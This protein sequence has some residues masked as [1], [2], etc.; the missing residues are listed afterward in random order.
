MRATAKRP[1]KFPKATN[2]NS[3]EKKTNYISDKPANHKIA[4]EI[5][6]LCLHP[7]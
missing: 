1:R 4:K 6:I 5:K 2:T 7:F 3:R